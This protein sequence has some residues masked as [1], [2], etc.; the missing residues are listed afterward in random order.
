LSYLWW[1][2][3]VTQP[4]APLDSVAIYPITQ[5]PNKQLETDKR[6]TFALSIRLIL[7]TMLHAPVK[8]E[9]FTWGLLLHENFDF[10]PHKPLRDSFVNT[11]LHKV[12]YHQMDDKL[13]TYDLLDML[14]DTSQTYL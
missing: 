2:D 11:H 10:L 13:Q 4:K 7:M 14:I 8:P 1:C 6:K 5:S 12:H 3:Q 9:C